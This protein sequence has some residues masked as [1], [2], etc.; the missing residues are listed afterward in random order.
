MNGYDILNY[1]MFI[2]LLPLSFFWLRKAWKV[3]INKDYSCVALKRGVAPENPKRFAIFT[4]IINLIGGLFLFGLFI[5]ILL[6]GIYN[7]YS[8]WTS[9]AGIT[10]WMK[11]IAD[12]I[13]SRQAHFN[14]MLSKTGKDLH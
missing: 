1:L 7:Y 8:T 4:I 9:A 2:G 6:T 5:F 10:L 12:F 13:L 3:G 11:F 14:K